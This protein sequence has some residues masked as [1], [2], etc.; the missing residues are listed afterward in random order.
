MGLSDVGPVGP[1]GPA[2][3]ALVIVAFLRPPLV[4]TGI[5]SDPDMLVSVDKAF[6]A[7]T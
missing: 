2:S 5:T 6:I 1:V 3:E 7:Q 4:I